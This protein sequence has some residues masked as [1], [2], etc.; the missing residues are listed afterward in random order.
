MDKKEKV[1]YEKVKNPKTS[2]DWDA[3]TKFLMQQ[4]K[5]T[6][7]AQRATAKQEKIQHE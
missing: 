3:Q 5:A 2:A 1:V 7:K 4:I 6:I